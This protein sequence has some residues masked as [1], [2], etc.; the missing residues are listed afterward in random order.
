MKHATGDEALLQNV[1][2]K[3]YGKR[4]FGRSKHKCDDNKDILENSVSVCEMHAVGNS[5]GLSLY[6]NETRA[7]KRRGIS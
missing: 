2:W 7:E 4:T 5:S 1:G 3:P 6:D